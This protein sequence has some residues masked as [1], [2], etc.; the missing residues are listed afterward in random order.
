M[1]GISGAGQKVD[2]RQVGVQRFRVDGLGFEKPLIL[3]V[4]SP[5]ESLDPKPY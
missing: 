5:T 4:A 1:F 3:V 2:H